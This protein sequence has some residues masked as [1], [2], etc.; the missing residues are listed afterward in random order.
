M[1]TYIILQLS[2]FSSVSTSKG[3]RGSV[4][5]EGEELKTILVK[6]N[7]DI[8]N[9]IKEIETKMTSPDTDKKYIPVNIR[10]EY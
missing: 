9:K 4:K 10:S 8:T 7:I 1:F 3:W 5:E 6:I 2:I